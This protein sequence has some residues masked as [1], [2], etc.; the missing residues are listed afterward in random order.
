MST[1]RV[2]ALVLAILLLLPALGMLIGGAAGSIAYAT[3]R[4][5]DGYFDV[6]LTGL[7]SRSAAVISDD[8]D[9]GSDP[10]PPEWV[11]D[12]GDISTQFGVQSVRSDL[13]LF[14]GIGPDEAVSAYLAGVTHERVADVDGRRL[15]LEAELG[16]SSSA[17]PPADETFWV[18]SAVGTGEQ[19]IEWDLESG[20]WTV[21]VMNADGSPGVAADIDVG[22]KAGFLLPLFITLLVLGLLGTIAAVV[23]L[24]A[25]VHGRGA[26]GAAPSGAAPGDVAHPGTEPVALEARLDP[27]LSAWQ[28]LVKWFL[29]IPHWIVLFFLWIAFIVLTVV[30]GFSILFTGSYPRGIFDFNVGVLRWTWRVQYYAAMGGLGTDRYPPFS[31]GPEPDYP[32][33]LD[34]ERPERLS[35]GL[36]LVKWWLL[37]IPHYLVLAIVVGGGIGA[38]GSADD[39]GGAAWGIG[40]LGLLVFFAGVSLL[41]RNRYPRGLFDLIVGLNRWVYRVV[42]Y[43]ALMTDQYPPFRL[44]QGGAE[45]PS[46]P[47]P[48][49]QPSDDVDLRLDTLPPPPVGATPA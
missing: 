32:A 27:D 16:E 33:T 49:D 7:Q 35:R 6:S 15:R 40:L 44:D 36:V 1:R 20:S 26:T 10:G 23:I 2:I 5:D 21:V 25:A 12:L 18:A 8:I 48:S 4:N 9:L 24:V 13:P 45:P 22:I 41:F 37:A 46:P 19:Q 30:A 47:P 28:W 34:I 3:A 38:S 17:T 39:A 29:A 43:A 31:L 42:A 14:I 11:V